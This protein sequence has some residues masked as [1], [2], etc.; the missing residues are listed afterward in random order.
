MPGIQHCVRV[1]VYYCSRGTV[2]NSKRTTMSG[3]QHCVRVGVY[4]C[5]R[6][7]VQLGIYH[8]D[9]VLSILLY[10]KQCTVNGQQC[11]VYF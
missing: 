8:S 4:Y 3:I 1:G 6:T 9:S 11:Q 7:T 10:K 2:Y 5:T